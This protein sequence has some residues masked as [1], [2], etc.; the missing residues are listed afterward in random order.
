VLELLPAWL[1]TTSQGK[2][3][4]FNEKVLTFAELTSLSVVC[5]GKNEFLVMSN[6]NTERSV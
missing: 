4:G 5:E 1:I 2:P 6:V 3:T